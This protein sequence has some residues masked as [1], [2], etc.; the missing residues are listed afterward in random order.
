MV[1]PPLLKNN[2]EWIRP[3]HIV[4]KESIPCRHN[5][6][7]GLL[8]NNKKIIS[9]LKQHSDCVVFTDFCQEQYDTVSLKKIDNE[10]EYSCNLKNSNLFM[11]EGETGFLADA[12]YNNK[13]S[14]ISTNF[15]DP[16]CIINS[17]MSERY[18][19]G[20]TE[21]NDLGKL[22]NIPINHQY[23][24]SVAQLHDKIEEYC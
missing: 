19:L 1:D 14:V 23:S 2:F 8:R 7:V 6:V 4:G 22:A 5:I 17:V 10:I 24:S 3:Y 12:F 15:D 18:H 9:L 16:E 13:Y 11:C 20:S 21:Y